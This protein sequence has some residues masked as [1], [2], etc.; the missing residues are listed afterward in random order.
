MRDHG[1]LQAFGLADALVLHVYRVTR[2]FPSDERFGL[3]TQ[4]RRA[5]VSVAAN[6]VEGCACPTRRDYVRFVWTAFASCREVGYLL[7][8]ATRLDYFDASHGGVASQLQGRTAAALAH[9][10]RSHAAELPK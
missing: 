7:T 10:I 8:V 9:L 4:L 1:R 3:V 2:H 5:A 6:I